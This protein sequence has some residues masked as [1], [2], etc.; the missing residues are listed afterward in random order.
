M[1]YILDDGL[2]FGLGVFETI[3]VTDGRLE[4]LKE[5]MERING[6]LQTLGIREGVEEDVLFNW[7]NNHTIPKKAAVKLLVTRENILLSARENHYNREM[8]ENGFVMDF[9]CVLRNDT[10]PLV[11]HKS[12]NYG[13]CI[14][15][16]RKAGKK[17]LDE[18]IFINR[19]E[20]ICE[21]AV[22]NVFFIKD[23]EIMTPSV[24]CGLLP[25]VMRRHV[26][27]SCQVTE[28]R[29]K[30]EEIYQM[31]GCFVTNSLMGIMPVRVLDDMDFS[32]R[33]EDIRDL[34]QMDDYC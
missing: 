23:D 29:I 4:L 6:S 20:E 21:G 7:L 31:D 11:R 12:L 26:M 28:R 8:K 24:D 3:A 16:K 19:F 13:D 27:E 22:S 34:L 1:E 2:S 9:S 14:M 32:M 10:S 25:G 33:Y 5:H 18:V 15:E 30:K 17:G